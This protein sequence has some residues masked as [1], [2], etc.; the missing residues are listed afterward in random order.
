MI[1]EIGI[2]K[3][4][5]QLDHFI[6][7]GRIVRTSFH[8]LIPDL[9]NSYVRSQPHNKFMRFRAYSEKTVIKGIMNYIP[10]FAS[11]KLFA[12]ID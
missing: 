5:E 12:Y 9:I 11:E 8:A 10:F 7:S 2:I 4:C 1:K 6:L 3:L